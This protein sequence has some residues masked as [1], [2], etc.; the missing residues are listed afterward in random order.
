[1]K[2]L[3]AFV[4]IFLLTSCASWSAGKSFD[5]GRAGAKTLEVA[6]SVTCAQESLLN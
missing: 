5:A 1:M 2:K 6:A 4:S 3:T